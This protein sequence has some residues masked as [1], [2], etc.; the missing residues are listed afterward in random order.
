MTDPYP[1]LREWAAA[2]ADAGYVR[3]RQVLELL[4]DAA[5]SATVCGA[6]KAAVLDVLDGAVTEVDWMNVRPL[7]RSAL[8]AVELPPCRTAG[9]R[10]DCDC[11]WA[12]TGEGGY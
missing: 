10:A 12:A 3:A 5:H 4:A 8:P 11:R 6:M 1:G 7:L 2:H 9:H